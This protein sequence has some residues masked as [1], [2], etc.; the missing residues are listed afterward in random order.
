MPLLSFSRYNLTKT[1]MNT[2]KLICVSLTLC[3]SASVTSALTLEEVAARSSLWPFNISVVEEI[4]SIPAAARKFPG[5]LL[6]IEDGQALIDYGR[7]GVHR[8]DLAATDILEA[9]AR[10][11]S[12]EV[13]P[14]L[15]NFTRYTTNIFFA[16]N[17]NDAYAPIPVDKFANTERYLVVYAPARIV[18][19]EP[20]FEAIDKLLTASDAAGNAS[21]VLGLGPGFYK[22]AAS[23]RIDWTMVQPHS[24][25][26]YS[27]ALRHEPEA[28]VTIVLIDAYGKILNRV[29]LDYSSLLDHSRM[30]EMRAQM[31]RI[32]EATAVHLPH[33]TPNEN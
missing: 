1:I 27:E 12:G 29:V 19:E 13:D 18:Q 17:S 10:L 11:Q 2:L 22:A 8:V 15:A 24:S 6:R 20:I 31:V 3:A 23:K 9:S 30:D 28:D 4:P 32:S 5:V 26:A 16:K 33:F 14:D 25:I 21:V 7:D